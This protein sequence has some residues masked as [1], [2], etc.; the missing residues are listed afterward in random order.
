MDILSKSR[1][2]VC[3]SQFGGVDL[4]GKKLEKKEILNKWQKININE[5][6]NNYKDARNFA[7]R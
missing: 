6:Y 5:N 1:N 3:T 7:Y 4:G 2:R